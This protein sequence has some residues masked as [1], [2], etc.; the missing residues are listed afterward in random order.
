MNLTDLFL[1]LFAMSL[2]ASYCIL[3]I[4][5]ARLFLRRAPKL[6]S[7]LLW[8]IVAVHLICPVAFESDFSFMGKR[9]LAFADRIEAGSDQ[10]IDTT[11][12]PSAEP[13]SVAE[14]Q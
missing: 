5:I 11:A 4:C 6:F 13:F 1:K 8:S 7:Y 12:E 3:F 14:G 2:T 10:E 9:F